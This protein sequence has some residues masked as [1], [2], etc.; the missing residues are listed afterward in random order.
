MYLSVWLTGSARQWRQATDSKGQQLPHIALVY[1]HSCCVSAPP[2]S[3]HAGQGALTYTSLQT[4]H[5]QQRF[6][7][8][9]K[10]VGALH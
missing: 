7:V 4:M 3:P 1:L 5:V 9:L 10:N 8:L 6:L 2:P